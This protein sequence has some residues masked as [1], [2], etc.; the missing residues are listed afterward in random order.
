MSCGYSGREL[1]LHVARQ[2]QQLTQEIAKMGTVI[3]DQHQQVLARLTALQ[4]STAS[5]V[6]VLEQTDLDL[7]ALAAKLAANPTAAN[8]TDAL[9]QIA[10]I[11][12]NIDSAVTAA[13]ADANYVPPAAPAEAPAAASTDPAPTS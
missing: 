2:Q 1:L 4:A 5:I 11:Q 9:T 8:Y 3:T 6:G 12:Q 13:K 7:D 10:A